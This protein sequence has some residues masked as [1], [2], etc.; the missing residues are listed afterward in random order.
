MALP[1]KY[2][3]TTALPKLSTFKANA[4]SLGEL[5]PADFTQAKLP[6]KSYLARKIST[7]ELG[8]V[9]VVVASK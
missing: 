1:E 6:P 2:P 3:D 7:V 8:L 9:A 5:P 4:T